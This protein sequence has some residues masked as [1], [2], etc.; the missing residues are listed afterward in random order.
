MLCF[1]KLNNFVGEKNVYAN[2]YFI[3]KLFCNY[4]KLC[5]LLTLSC[6]FLSLAILHQ[7]STIVLIHTTLDWWPTN[8]NSISN[9]S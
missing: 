4:F 8:M 3:S 1:D 5:K 7:L 2:L 6:F 9:D